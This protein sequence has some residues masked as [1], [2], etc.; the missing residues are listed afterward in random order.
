MSVNFNININVFQNNVI[1]TPGFGHMGLNCF[2][3]NMFTPF[4]GVEQMLMQFQQQMLMGMLA[5]MMPR[6]NPGMFMSNTAGFRPAP[7]GSRVN[8]LL[9]KH[10]N[11][12]NGLARALNVSGRKDVEKI[13]SAARQLQASPGPTASL[14]G[15]KPGVGGKKINV[16]PDVA[17]QIARAGSQAEGEK[18][19]RAWLTKASGSSDPRT[20]LNKVMGTNI[21]SGREKNSGSKLMLDT[22]V[23]QSVKTIQ[24][25]RMLDHCGRPTCCIPCYNCPVSLDF[26]H[27]TYTKAANDIGGLASPLTLDLDGDGKY[28]SDRE[29]KFDIDGDGTKELVNDVD[30]GDALLVWDADGDGVAGENGTELLGDNTQAF[31]GNFKNGFEALE[32]MGR[33]E[34]LLGNGDNELDAQDLQ[35]LHEKYGLAIR[36]GGLNGTDSTSFS[37]ADI[38]M[39]RTG[40]GAVQQ[41]Q[42]EHNNEVARRDGAEFVRTDGSV[43]DMV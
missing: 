22:M 32:A 39:L 29:V 6:I 28:V 7:G 40:V 4:P 34:G 42:I 25:G 36:R 43:G 30:E 10:G 37:D 38:A 35:I 9:K 5:S 12:K 24:S 17:N 8:D 15:G 41:S 23:E 18:I 19:F 1:N 16:P 2:C 3:G 27:G 26:N 21:R 20:T 31:G 11:D 33:K 13:N 14:S